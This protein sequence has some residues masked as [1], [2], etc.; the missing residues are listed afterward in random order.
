MKRSPIGPGDAPQRMRTLLRCTALT[1]MSGLTS[2]YQFAVS[3]DAG[4]AQLKLDGD[5]GYVDGASTV[6]FQQDIQSAF[7][8]GDK[9][10][11]PYGRVSID[12][13]VPVVTVSGFQF[14]ESGEGV[15]QANFGDSPLLIAGTPVRS[16]I[17]LANIKGSYL[18]QIDL[19]PVAIS[20]GIA[21]DWF[22]LDVRVRDRFGIADERVELQAPVPLLMLRGEV[23]LGVVGAMA[24]VGYLEVDVDDIQASLLD[25]EAMLTLKPAWW[26]DLFAGYR[27]LAIDADGLVDGDSVDADL[28]ISGF[29]VGGGLRF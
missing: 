6:N 19:G 5:L 21:V 29:I 8:L 28:T 16:D 20:P 9:Q 1:L 13:G 3:A 12:T 2:C 26:F 10:G 7:G 4:Y 14:D 25:I 18:F 24:E 27:S 22:D 17:E 11:T 23:D 15:L